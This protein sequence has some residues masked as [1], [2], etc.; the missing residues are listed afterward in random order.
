MRAICGGEQ[1]AARIPS[2]P[3]QLRGSIDPKID[4]AAGIAHCGSIG[5]RQHRAA[6]GGDY[7]SLACQGFGKR[8]RL[9]VA[10]AGLA[11]V[12]EQGGDVAAGST[13]NARI[14]V[15]ENQTKPR[16]QPAT[17]RA[18]ARS[19]RADQ[20]DVSCVAHRNMLAA[21]ASP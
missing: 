6:A 17:E 1:G 13:F 8:L 11:F 2:Q 7:C 5:V 4:H 16:R 21:V 10:E 18:L 12:G 14:H 20:D 19:H 9:A 15:H 3:R